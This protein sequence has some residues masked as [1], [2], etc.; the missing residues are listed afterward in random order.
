MDSRVSTHGDVLNII[1]AAGTES[2]GHRD[3]GA[4]GG[5]GQT[6]T[7]SLTDSTKATEKSVMII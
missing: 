5:G 3:G 6:A 4:G 2:E 1:H 7:W